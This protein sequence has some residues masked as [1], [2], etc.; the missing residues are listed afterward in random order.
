[1]EICLNPKNIE[2][3]LYGKDDFLIL[4]PPF[5][6]TPFIEVHSYGNNEYGTKLPRLK[7]FPIYRDP[8][9]RGCTVLQNTINAVLEHLFKAIF[10]GDPH[11]LNPALLQLEY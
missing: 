6:T 4:G 5:P 9:Y 3:T 10:M 2:V 7:R 1:M 8:T 11:K